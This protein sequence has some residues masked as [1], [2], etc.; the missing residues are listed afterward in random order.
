MGYSSYEPSDEEAFAAASVQEAQRQEES[1][2]IQQPQS[3]IQGINNSA[4]IILESQP[5]ESAD[6]YTQAVLEAQ[7]I[8]L[9]ISGAVARSMNESPLKTQS[10]IINFLKKTLGFDP[11]YILYGGGAFLIL[12]LILP[13]IGVQ[14]SLSRSKR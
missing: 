5:S 12:M 9:S 4:A 11:K 13:S 14:S 1:S 10:D 3:V 8:M 2:I 6:P 7:N